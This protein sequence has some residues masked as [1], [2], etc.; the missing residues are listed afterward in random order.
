MEYSFVFTQLKA[1]APS[2]SAGRS[3]AVRDRLFIPRVLAELRLRRHFGQCPK[4]WCRWESTVNPLASA[5]CSWIFSTA[6]LVNSTIVPH[7][8]QTIWS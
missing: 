8:V 6:S 1:E 2:A 5:I 4:I 3:G 7:R